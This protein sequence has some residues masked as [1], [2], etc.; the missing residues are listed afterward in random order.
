[1]SLAWS[2][3]LFYCFSVCEW[4][5]YPGNSAIWLFPGEGGLIPSL[6]MFP[7][8]ENNDM[9]AQ[10]SVELEKLFQLLPQ[11]AN[12]SSVKHLFYMCLH[13]RK[14]WAYKNSCQLLFVWILLFPIPRIES[15]WCL[16]TTKS[17]SRK[18]RKCTVVL[19]KGESPYLFTLNVPTDQTTIFSENCEQRS[20]YRWN[21]QVNQTETIEPYIPSKPHNTLWALEPITSLKS[22]TWT[23]V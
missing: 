16:S 3:C 18:R 10:T 7:V 13:K 20:F 15:L 14:K 5:V 9:K 19:I 2:K 12:L 6:S 17:I 22:D 4:A 23:I 8:D 1:M 21:T 11:N